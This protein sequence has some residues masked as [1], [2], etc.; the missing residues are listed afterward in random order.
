MRHPRERGAPRPARVPAA[1][2]G[3]SDRALWEQRLPGAACSWKAA[4]PGTGTTAAPFELARRRQP[5]HA[6]ALRRQ[7]GDRGQPRARGRSAQDLQ[8]DRLPRQEDPQE[9]REG[10]RGQDRDHDLQHDGRGR[11]E[12]SERRRRLRRL[13]PDGRPARKA[14]R[15]KLLQPVTFSYIP[16]LEANIWPQLTSPFYDV[17]SR[18]T[19]PYVI[20][21]TGIGTAQT[22]STRRRTS[23]LIRTT[24]TS[25][26]STAARPICSTTTA[27]RCASCSFAT[28]S[29]T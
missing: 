1:V 27:R 5:G 10:V 25:K 3:R 8:L 15:G 11:R 28:E 6:A 23:S 20:Y 2:G 18:Y 24:S 13:L 29:P 26:R 12:A 22:T 16:N 19:V 14:R 9:V 17:G 4:T 7:P 21:T